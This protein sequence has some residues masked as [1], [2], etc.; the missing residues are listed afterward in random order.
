MKLI[1]KLYEETYSPKLTPQ[2]LL[3]NLNLDNYTGINFQKV[4]GYVIA[5]TFCYLQNGLQAEYRYYFIE[6]SLYKLESVIDNST[7]TIYNRE[8]EKQKLVN[9]IKGEEIIKYA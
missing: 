2:T 1:H 3:M 9:K 4:D 6:D 5:S 7:E 8:I